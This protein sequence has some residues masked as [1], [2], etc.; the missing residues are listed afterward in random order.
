MM[1][2]PEVAAM[3]RDL[4]CIDRGVSDAERVEQLRVLEE[5]KAAAAAA[6][7]LV[8]ADFAASQEAAQVAAGTPAAE[9]GRGVAAQ[10]GLAKRESPARARRYLGWAKVVTTELPQTFAA[11]ACGAATEWRAML[12]A[13]ETACLSAEH[14]AAVDAE[15]GDRL[16]GWGDRQ[17]EAETRRIA[18][19]L[20]PYAV[21]AR[22]RRAESERRV[23]LRPAPDT[24]AK[25][26]ALLPVAQGV[27]VYA[28]LG[29]HADS[30]R[31][32][33]DE[34]G[35][36]QIMADTLV[37]RVTGQAQAAAVPVGV[38]LVITDAALLD[39]AQAD[40]ARS[41]AGERE[42]PALLLGHGPVPAPWARDLVRNADSD[43]QVWLRRLFT[44]P[45]GGDLAGMDSRRRAFDGAAARLPD[46]AR[47]GLPHP[48][49]R[50]ARPPPRPRHPRRTRRTDQRRKRAG[51]LRGLQPRQTGPRLDHRPR[52]RRRRHRRD[53]QHPDRPLLPEP[54]PETA[55]RAVPAMATT[56]QDQHRR[57]TPTRTRARRV[58]QRA[59]RTR[60]GHTPGQEALNT[61][62]ACHSRNSRFG[63][64]ARLSGKAMTSP[65]LA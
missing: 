45:G 35:R 11:L 10:V 27:A 39:C 65:D 20:D 15:I 49:V 55:R 17:V 58:T 59:R 3:V 13:R 51:L 7:A 28:A 4:R 2:G 54:T 14:R 21:T 47:P 9:V 22:A 25:L 42:E 29:A 24:M 43:A 1:R 31:A 33:G 19:R 37:E 63:R 26:S 12:V 61:V 36:G 5:L 18:Y 57:T 38:N 44:R 48:L 41:A 50:R 64:L 30:C 34:R 8:T 62:S 53:H 60:S 16:A 23:S 46:P 52:R 6:Q 32:G 40:A 56:T